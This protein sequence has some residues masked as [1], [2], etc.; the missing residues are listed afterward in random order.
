LEERGSGEGTTDQE[1]EAKKGTKAKKTLAEKEKEKTLDAKTW[2]RDAKLVS[3]ATALLQ[4]IGDGLFEDHNVFREHVDAALDKLGIKL[5]AAE[6][7]LI[8]RTVSWREDSAPP[9]IA[10]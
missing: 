7:K 1:E 3:A 2:E 4:D 5:T 6:K 9:V 8:L 10:K